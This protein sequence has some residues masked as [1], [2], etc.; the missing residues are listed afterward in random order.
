MNDHL[1]KDFECL[2]EEQKIIG[3]SPQGKEFADFDRWIKDL[4]FEVV[5]KFQPFLHDLAVGIDGL[6]FTKGF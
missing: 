3:V 2:V 6:C 4:A 1:L 5:E